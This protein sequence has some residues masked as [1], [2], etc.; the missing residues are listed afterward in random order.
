MRIL[1]ITFSIIGAILLNAGFYG[2]IDGI[3]FFG[4][5]LALLLL[6]WKIIIAIVVIGIIIAVIA[7]I[8]D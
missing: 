1:K 4:G 5:I 8:F 7:A 2:L 6:I 3:G